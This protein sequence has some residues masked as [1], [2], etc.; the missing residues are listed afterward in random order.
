M[1]S[2]ER[3]VEAL[4]RHGSSVRPDRSGVVANCPAP[5]HEDRHP[6]LGVTPIEGSVLLRCRSRG[7]DN[8]DVLAALGLNL[9]DLYDAPRGNVLT[10]YVYRDRAG[11]PTRTV[12]RGGDGKRFTQSG[13]TRERPELYRLPKV[14]E[15]VAAGRTVYLTEGE[16][17]VHALESLGVVATTS[18]MGASNWSKVD[19]A[20]LAGA[21]VVVVPDNDAP[22]EKYLADVLATLS[23]V[24]AS[25]RVAHAKEGKDAADHVAAGYGLD[26]LV[27]VDLESVAAV[28]LDDVR[29]F[30]ARFVAFPSL[31]A[32]DAVTLWAA[33]AHTVHAGEN[34]PRL[35]LLS[36]EPGSGKTRTLEVLEALVPAPMNVLS[37]S[38][39]AVFRSIESERPTLLMD[40]V[41]AIFSRR[42][43]ED[44]AEDL[45]A[46]LNAGHRKGA[47]IPRCVGPRHD[48]VRFPVFAAA[49][50]AGLGDLPDTLMSRSVIIR[51]RRRAPSEQVQPW[52]HRLHA[53]AGEDLGARLAD[54]AQL[55]ADTIG[56][57]W[58]DMPDGITD[59][60]ADVW[61]PLLAVADAAGGHWPETARVACV[62]LSKVAASREASL[63]VKLLA[64]LREVFGD[65]DALPTET[66]L[67]RLHKLDESPWAD[68]RGKPL[69]ARG[70]AWRLRQ[71]EVLSVKVKIDGRALQGYR[72]EHL[73]DTWAR[74]L[75]P[76]PPEAE[77][78]EP[79][80]PRRSD[81]E[82]EVPD[83]SEVP[84]PAT[85]TEPDTLPLTCG[86]P[87]VPQ[88]PDLQGR[89]ALICSVCLEPLDPVNAAAGTH[90]GCEAA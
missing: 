71:Y 19:P 12:H 90:P 54:W 58:P 14:L 86:V 51:M 63:G 73:W 53:P 39:A 85:G 55:N 23:G 18:P 42:G 34:T 69:D 33:H 77:P 87:E 66:I 38:P 82:P 78:R 15:A 74:Y 16:K 83:A 17:D 88:V 1:T 60:P 25:L 35:A 36:P 44:G 59:R 40:E 57:A 46:L 89:R 8:C 49:A 62:E 28:L 67:D 81:P 68:L 10:D 6:S 21:H 79:A 52:R 3:V 4:E 80:E 70:L 26:D 24:A 31:A 75:T 48:V 13:A 47:T 37:A 43:T 7:C 5:G 45:R 22:G 30:I 61:E 29:T 72:R 65:T 50:L 84:E 2:Y 32:L 9:R 76:A 64:D 56:Q 41:D 27:P 20:P 11:R